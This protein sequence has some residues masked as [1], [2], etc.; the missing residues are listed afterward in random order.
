M[1]TP[2]WIVAALLAV[3]T[4]RRWIY[5]AASL[6]PRRLGAP[7][8]ARSIVVLVAARN[9][10]QRLPRLLSALERTE[11]PHELLSF[12]IAS[13]GSTDATPDLARAWAGRM[14]RAQALVLPVRRGKGAALQAA[15]AASPASD[16]VAVVDAD[17]QPQPAALAWL[18]GAFDDPAV[19]AACAY[20]DPGL[21]HTTTAAKYAALERWVSHLVTFAGKDRLALQPPVIGA[22]CCVRTAALAQI[23]GFPQG[24]AE[25]IQLSMELSRKRWKSRWIGRAVAREDVPPDLRAFRQQRL[26]WSRG[27]MSSGARA[28]GLEDLMVAAGYLDRLAFVAGVVLAVLGRLPAWLPLAYAAAPMVVILTALWRAGAPN[29]LGYLWSVAPMAFVDIGVTLESAIAQVVGTPLHW[30]SRADA[31]S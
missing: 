28:S 20:P 14:P 6:L 7:S 21:A 11:Y 13:D 26:R 2:A 24:M 22:F 3:F 23:G 1:T 5:W 29:K 19:G 10:E 4:V 27:L 16:L 17:T 31:P 18:A 30:R 9:E 15:F 12:V 8:R 25:D